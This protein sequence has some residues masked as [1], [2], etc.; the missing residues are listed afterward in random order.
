MAQEIL[1]WKPEG[2]TLLTKVDSSG[3]TPLQFAVMHG[4]LDVVQL[5]LDERTSMEQVHISDNRGLYAVHTAAMV[6]RA[7][8]IDEL[9]KKCPDY[10]GLVDDKGRNLLHCAVEHHQETVVR[11]ICQNDAFAV[12]LNATDYEGNTPLHLAVKHGFPRIVSL[13]L[14]TMT[15]ETGVTNKCGLTAGDLGRRALA[16]GRWYY[17]LVSLCYLAMHASIYFFVMEMA[18]VLFGFII[19]ANS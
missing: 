6:G 8:I 18:L 11:H 4:K 1:N 3:R 7:G 12:L 9:I 19:N 2:P 5:F 17:F 15:V 16:P 14:Q 10:Y 13:L